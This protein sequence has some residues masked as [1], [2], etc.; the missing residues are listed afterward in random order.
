MWRV[1]RAAGTKTGTAR[2]NGPGIIAPMTERGL[3][4]MDG[5]PACPFVAFGDDR[6][7]VRRAPTTAIDASPSH[8]RRRA[9][10]PTRK[11]TAC[12]ARSPSARRS[13]T[14]RGARPRTPAAAAS[15]PRRR[16][17]PCRCHRRASR[18]RRRAGVASRRAAPPD[19]LPVQRNPPRDWAA[20][21]PWAHGRRRAAGT[22][23]PRRR[24]STGAPAPPDAAAP[25]S[26][27]SI[28]RGPGA[29]RQRGRSAGRRPG[30]AVGPPRSPPGRRPPPGRSRRMPDEDLA[31]LVSRPT[32]EAASSGRG[33]AATRRR[34]G[35]DAGQ[36]SA[37]PARPGTRSRARHGRGCAG[38]RPIR[39]SRRGPGCPA[40][41]A[42]DR[43]ASP[44][45]SGSRRSRCSCCPRCSGSVAVTRRPVAE[46]QP[47]RRDRDGAPPTPVPEPSAQIYVIKTGDTLSKVAKSFGV[48]LEELLAANP[49]IKNPNVIAL[50]QQI[51]IPSPAGR[52]ARALRSHHAA[53]CR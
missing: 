30:P 41:R 19:D 33:A 45:R 18:P 31:G 13:R 7:V 1:K 51:V 4:S 14:G 22:V 48:T 16:R 36:R 49:D 50:G 27:R 8:R 5:A 10:W 43:G 12:R 52:P 42:T 44:V 3:P 26:R 47:A 17:R 29:R 34:R 32:S 2:G 25:G 40:C 37:P 53:P 38:T 46:P 28:E 23:P 39:R 9:P 11:P 20:P 35:P 24:A 21:P 6:E 15:D